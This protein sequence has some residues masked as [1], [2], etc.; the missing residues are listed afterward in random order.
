MLDF[1]LLPLTY[2]EET[3]GATISVNIDGFEFNIPYNWFIIVTDPDTLQLD[4]IPIAE[5]STTISYALIMTPADGK[6]RNSRINVTNVLSN[7]SEIHPML[8]K[9]TALCH[10]I[11][12]IDIDNNQKTIANI[13]I[14]PYDLFKFLDT[15]L[16]GDLI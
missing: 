9:T 1:T 13:V 16:Y 2:L 11:G 10:P 8:Q 12:E 4:S 6:F 14:G 5:C 3:F 7:Q 15:K